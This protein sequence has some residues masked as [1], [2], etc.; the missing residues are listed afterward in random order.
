MDFEKVGLIAVL[1]T[2]IRILNPMFLGL[3]DPD[4]SDIWIRFHNKMS[5]LCNTA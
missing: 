3:P 1:R 4:W 2:R 5:W